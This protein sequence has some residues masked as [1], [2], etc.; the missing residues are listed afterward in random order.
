MKLI[1]FYKDEK[2]PIRGTLPNYGGEVTRAPG[3]NFNEFP[4]AMKRTA[5]TYWET[6]EA[7]AKKA[8]GWRDPNTSEWCKYF[9]R[10]VMSD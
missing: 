6:V 5:L 3:K 9:T 4:Y 1:L 2:H 7:A 8:A 10:M